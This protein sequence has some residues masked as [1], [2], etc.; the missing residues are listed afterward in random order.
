MRH[1]STGPRSAASTPVRHFADIIAAAIKSGDEAAEPC[2]ESAI[3]RCVGYP[4]PRNLAD[5]VIARLNGR[6]KKR[7]GPTA[8][9]IDVVT[10]RQM[11]V[12]MARSDYPEVKKYVD[13]CLREGDDNGNEQLKM[14]IYLNESSY[15]ATLRLIAAIHFPGLQ[16]RTVGNLLKLRSRDSNDPTTMG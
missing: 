2:L 13:R 12:L 3:R 7:R 1:N 11:A 5:V 8:K 16:A 6:H 4:L 10:K 9:T 15:E 14:S